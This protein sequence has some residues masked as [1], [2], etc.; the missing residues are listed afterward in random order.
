MNTLNKF[1]K[2]EMNSTRLIALSFLGV[3][4]I[5][6]ILLSLP[7]ANIGPNRAIIDHLFVA[8]SATCVT[9]LVTVVPSEQY[10][11]FGQL[12]I[13]IMIQ[14]GGL[15]FLTFLMLLLVKLRKRLSLSN[16]MLMQEAFN[17]N[18]LKN[19]SF[20]ITRVIHFTFIVE[21]IGACC[22]SVVFI[23]EYGFLKGIYYSIFHSISA[24]CN[25]GFDVLGS[26]SLI[27]YQSNP[28]I[29]I[30]IPCLIIAGGLG[31]LVWFDCFDTWKN[32]RQ[33]KSIKKLF[34]SLSLH[35]R[36]VLVMSGALLVITTVLFYFLERNNPNTIGNL[37]S[38]DQL[39]V[40]FFTSATYRTAG[41]AT[42]PMECMLDPSKMIACIIMFIGG[43]PA[44]TAGGIKTVTFAL[45]LLMIYHTYKGNNEVVIWHRRIKK[46]IILR[47][48]AIVA[49]SLSIVLGALIVLS[50][51]ETAHFI[52]LMFETFS[53]FAT[54]G[55]SVG[56][57]AS[58][59]SFGKVIIIIL[60][61]IGRIGPVS[62][63]IL[64]AKKKLLNSG[65]N[66]QYPDEDIL[67]G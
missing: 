11:I 66:I 34:H 54:V 50:M 37:S 65:N 51:S 52:D 57:S 42:F 53:A 24:F 60:M 6:C 40:S 59:S 29:N 25:A 26:N 2:K 47:S 48:F 9:G 20:F 32:K 44:G 35:S 14:L 12:V 27:N 13:L 19:M 56:I 43:S 21:L 16:R 7:I 64:F 63:V 28:I 62:M 58:L 4:I 1:L 30:V 3:I 15:G 45:M 18:S 36:I 23:P 5:G 22:L 39:Q 61:Y 31:F 46:R 55:L 67:V 8:T 17:Q 41:F 10:S 49:T 38:L 33:N